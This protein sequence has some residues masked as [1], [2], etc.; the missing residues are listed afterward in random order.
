MQTG[1]LIW[2]GGG[3]LI[4]MSMYPCSYLYMS[5]YQFT[6]PVGFGILVLVISLAAPS[7]W[8]SKNNIQFISFTNVQ[9]CTTSAFC[10]TTRED[11]PYSPSGNNTRVVLQSC[12][13]SDVLNVFHETYS[14]T[15]PHMYTGKQ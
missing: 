10:S 5:V 13:Q 14:C 4:C 15:P 11:G 3:V 6:I 1:I 8:K 12:M 9:C 7:V 2:S